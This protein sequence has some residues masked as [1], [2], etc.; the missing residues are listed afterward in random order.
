MPRYNTGQQKGIKIKTY[1]SSN[2]TAIK[3]IHYIFYINQ[4]MMLADYF[5]EIEQTTNSDIEII[6]DYHNIK[7][8]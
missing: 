1:E 2:D 5:D 4:K 8:I 6:I 7:P 3:F